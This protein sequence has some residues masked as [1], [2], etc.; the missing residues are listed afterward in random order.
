MQE[1][2]TKRTHGN[3]ARILHWKFCGLYQQAKA[4]KWNEHQP[5]GVIEPDDVKILW[6]FNIQCA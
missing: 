4:E 1:A 3:I 5:N 2:S 6:D